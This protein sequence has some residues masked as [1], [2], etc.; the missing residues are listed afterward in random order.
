MDYAHKIGKQKNDSRLQLRDCVPQNPC[1]P[2]KPAKSLR[3]DRRLA[4]WKRWLADRKRRQEYLAAALKREPID[5]ALNAHEKARAK[6]E[7]RCLLKAAA[8]TEVTNQDRY[9]GN[10]AFWRVEERLRKKPDNGRGDCYD[11]DV[12]VQQSR[13][14]RFLPPDI[15]R[16][17]LPAYIRK[18]KMLIE[19]HVDPAKINL[20]SNWDCGEYLKHR[21]AQLQGAMKHLEPKQPETEELMIIGRNGDCREEKDLVVRIP[22]IVIVPDEPERALLNDPDDRAALSIQNREFVLESSRHFEKLSADETQRLRQTNQDSNGEKYVYAPFDCERVYQILPEKCK[23]VTWTLHFQAHCGD[24]TERKLC[25]ENRGVRVVH[26]EWRKATAPGGSPLAVAERVDSRFFF[27]KGRL[28]IPPGQRVQVPIW[29]RSRRPVVTTETW[30]LVVD[31]TVYPGTLLLRLWAVASGEKGQL[32][33]DARYE[34]VRALLRRR[35]RDAAIREIIDDLIASASVESSRDDD[36]PY[37]AYF[38]ESELFQARNPGYHY[39]SLLVDELRRMHE[40]ATGERNWNL[41]LGGLRS[42]LVKLDDPI[43]RR[44]KLARLQAVCRECLLPDFYYAR[45]RASEKRLVYWLLCMFANRFEDE[46]DY[47]AR[48]CCRGV[49]ADDASEEATVVNELSEAEDGHSQVYVDGR[50]LEIYQQALFIRIHCLL[51][52]TIDNVCLVV[53]SCR[54]FGK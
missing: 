1:N 42:S 46:D 28:T 17:A 23:S 26:V 5:L 9:R 51:G 20:H 2:Q 33:R 30:R 7:T 39:K 48:C 22:L 35:A 12:I 52:Q 27:D 40:D 31:P 21:R 47:V 41:L 15:T 34:S 10:P 45:P 24:T 13:D 53:E 11:D 32:E 14:D 29:F 43:E 38:L 50:N 3:E 25:M 8:R 19:K 18:E 16:V 44:E 49:G 6:N 4:N 36:V 54:L 37:E